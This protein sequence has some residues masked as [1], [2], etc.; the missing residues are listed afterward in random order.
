MSTRH[1]AAVLVG[2][3]SFLNSQSGDIARL[4]LQHKMVT[5]FPTLRGVEDGGLIGYVN[6]MRY[7]FQSAAAYVDRILKGAKPG[8][9]PIEQP[10]KFELAVNQKTAK[11]LGIT[12]PQS[13]LLRAGRVIE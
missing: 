12:I 5:I 2:D 7:R 3:D 6:D 10:M 11:A 8:E 4:A 9:L 13:V 1:V